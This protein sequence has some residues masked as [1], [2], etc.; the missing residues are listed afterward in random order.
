[1]GELRSTKRGVYL[2]SQRNEG[3]PR[4]E[5]GGKSELA[6]W[7]GTRGGPAGD[8]S[9]DCWHC[10]A[11]AGQQYPGMEGSDDVKRILGSGNSWRLE[12]T[13]LGKRG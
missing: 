7:G 1:M 4:E 6:G 11:Q 2:F 3:W 13:R 12:T 8:K 5:R 9:G 10:G